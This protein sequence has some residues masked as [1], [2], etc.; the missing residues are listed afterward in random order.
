MNTDALDLQSLD[1]Q[2][3]RLQ[4]FKNTFVIWVHGL[5]FS[6]Y[7]LNQCILEVYLHQLSEEETIKNIQ[8]IG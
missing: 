6:M 5:D 1:I 3:R 2:S 4:I 8:L 7:T